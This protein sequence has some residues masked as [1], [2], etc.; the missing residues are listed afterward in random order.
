MDYENYMD[1]PEVNDVL[2]HYAEA[3]VLALVPPAMLEEGVEEVVS[4]VVVGDDLQVVSGANHGDGFAPV[5]V[6]GDTLVAAMGALNEGMEKVGVPAIDLF[7]IHVSVEDKE[8]VEVNVIPIWEDELETSVET[9]VET[10][11]DPVDLDF[12]KEAILFDS[13]AG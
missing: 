2:E 11:G 6:D 12:L 10:L 9:L 8:M 4:M 5:A 1:L 3:V 7:L 13:E